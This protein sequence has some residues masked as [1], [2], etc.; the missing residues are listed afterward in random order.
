MALADSETCIPAAPLVHML[1]RTVP[2][3][4]LVYTVELVVD[5]RYMLGARWE[6]A[7]QCIPLRFPRFS[8]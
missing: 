8:P 5:V 6:V 7:C 3:Q 4:L 2:V 1:V